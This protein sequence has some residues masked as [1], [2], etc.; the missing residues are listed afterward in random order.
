MGNLLLQLLPIVGTKRLVVNVM[1][2]SSILVVV[3]LMYPSSPLKM[4]SLKPNPL[5]VILN[6]VVKI[7]TIGWGTTSFC[8]FPLLLSAATFRCNL[9]LVIYILIYKF[10]ILCTV[11]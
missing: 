2:S 9:H 3:L 10:I 1:S 7:L 8:F 4:V 6:W 5:L 11:Y